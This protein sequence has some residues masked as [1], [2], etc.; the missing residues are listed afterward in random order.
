MDKKLERIEQL[1]KQI[2]TDK[3]FDNVI[4]M[5]TEASALIK[6]LLVQSTETRGRVLE[7]VR[8]LDEFIEK[9]IKC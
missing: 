8:E 7:L 9:E 2:E 6:E 3:N 4:K 5:F 1:T